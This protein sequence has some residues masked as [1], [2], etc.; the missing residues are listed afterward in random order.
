MSDKKVSPKCSS[1]EGT[2]EDFVIVHNEYL[3]DL[4]GDTIQFVCC[5]EFGTTVGVLPTIP[6]K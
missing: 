4:Y 5:K 1:P 3:G 2:S 6:S